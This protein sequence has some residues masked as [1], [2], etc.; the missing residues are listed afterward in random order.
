MIR[1]K[2][3]SP[4]LLHHFVDLNKLTLCILL[5]V[6]LRISFNSDFPGHLSRIKKKGLLTRCD[7]QIGQLKLGMH[8][9]K[10]LRVT[11]PA[12][13]LESAHQTLV[14]RARLCSLL[15]LPPRL[16][17]LLL[18]L[19]RNHRSPIR[20]TRL[21]LTA[22]PIKNPDLYTALDSIPTNCQRWVISI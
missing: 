16:F 14:T 21:R 19:V 2:S 12:D 20:Q 1:E 10:R 4:S 18:V 7:C 11:I 22:I 8:S 13:L 3:V 6:E 9:H 5:G 17:M 15:L